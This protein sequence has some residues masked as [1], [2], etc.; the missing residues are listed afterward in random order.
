MNAQLIVEELTVSR[1]DALML[2]RPVPEY[3][4]LPV[5]QA[6]LVIVERLVR[7]ASLQRSGEGHRQATGRVYSAEEDIRDG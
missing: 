1:F 7:G 4:L 6:V 2:V 3:F 5:E